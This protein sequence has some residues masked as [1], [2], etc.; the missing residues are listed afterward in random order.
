MK[1]L[2]LLILVFL[3]SF[4]FSSSFTNLKEVV[5]E[6]MK[7]IEVFEKSSFDTSILGFPGK[8]FLFNIFSQVWRGIPWRHDLLI[9]TPLKYETDIVF[10]YLT[11]GSFRFDRGLLGQ[12]VKL[13]NV[14]KIP[15]VV[16]Y[17]IPNQPLFGYTEDNLMAYTF[18]KFMETE[19]S[20]WILLYP[21]VKTVSTSLTFLNEYFKNNNISFIV[22]GVSKRGWTGWLS[23]VCDKR[24]KAIVP[25]SINL[26]NL[27]KHMELQIEEFGNYSQEL[28][29]YVKRGLTKEKVEEEKARKL[30]KIIDP[31]YYIDDLKIPK[32][33]LVGSNDPYWPITAG[34]LY[35]PEL[36]GEKFYIAMPNVG[37]TPNERFIESYIMAYLGIKEN[38]FPPK[39]ITKYKKVNNKII[40]EVKLEGYSSGEISLWYAE[41]NSKDFRWISFKKLILEKNIIEISPTKKYL[42]YFFD[43]V[44]NYK[45]FPIYSS[46]IPEIIEN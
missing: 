40:F 8:M 10:I 29:P 7:Y 19:D 43:F 11:G 18:E 4:S 5:K 31:F 15:V 46:T 13:A 45:N 14:T 30:L 1:Y 22:G 2:S 42:A 26:L 37:H 34:K 38:F 28:E 36:L 21:M 32:Y 24:I 39:I 25:S 3:F 27:E 44:G 35:F 9:I 23:A 20:T 33:I 41:N 17:D 16:I 12:A 6:N